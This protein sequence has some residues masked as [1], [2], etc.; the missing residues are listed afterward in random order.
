MAEAG[1][2]RAA[3]FKLTAEVGIRRSGA[4]PFRVQVFDASCAGCGI[5]FIERPAVGELVW[6]KFDGLEALEGTVRWIEG[7]VGG[8][9]FSHPIHGSVFEQLVAR[10]GSRTYGPIR[11]DEAIARQRQNIGSGARAGR[12]D[13]SS[14]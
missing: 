2:P 4:H 13:N 6:V 7:H 3:R 14:S 1:T 12:G 10:E 5:E 11:P 8:V 9:L